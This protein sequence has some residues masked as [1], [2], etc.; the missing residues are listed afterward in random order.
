M[1]RK[2]VP[3]VLGVSRPSGMA[4]TSERPV[5]PGQAKRHDRVN[6]VSDQHAHRRAR[7]HPG[8]NERPR[9][10]ENHNEQASPSRSC[11]PML[12]SISPKNAL[13]SPRR[14]QP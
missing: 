14:A 4:V 2:T 7:D 9:H 13:M 11:T 6:Q 5:L 1:I 3:N 8:Q 12:S 10:L